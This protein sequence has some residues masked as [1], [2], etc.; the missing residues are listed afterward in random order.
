MEFPRRRGDRDRARCRHQRAKLDRID[1]ADARIEEI[2]HRCGVSAPART[3]SHALSD[4]RNSDLLERRYLRHG[5]EWL[6]AGHRHDLDLPG[7]EQRNMLS[8]GP[9]WR[10]M[11]PELTLAGCRVRRLSQTAPVRPGP[12]TSSSGHN[13]G[14]RACDQ[15]S[16]CGRPL[17]SGP[18]LLINSSVGGVCHY[19]ARL[20]RYLFGIV[21]APERGTAALPSPAV[22]RARPAPP[23]E[24]LSYNLGGVQ[25]GPFSPG[26][27]R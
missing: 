16:D 3:P 10:W 18:F 1:R 26:C 15:S 5:D 13:A 2:N 22:R 7:L 24:R 8:G 9:I 6:V 12:R 17:P 20:A 19:C 14:A 27:Q 4:E 23:R 21:I 25:G 11:R